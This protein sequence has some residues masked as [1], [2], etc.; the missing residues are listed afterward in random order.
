MSTP[1]ELQVIV[2]HQMWVLKSELGSPS[3][4]FLNPWAIFL[5]PKQWVFHCH[6]TPKWQH[7]DLM[8]DRKG[9]FGLCPGVFGD[10]PSSSITVNPQSSVLPPFQNELPSN[11]LRSCL[12]LWAQAVTCQSHALRLSP[13]PALSSL[14]LPVGDFPYMFWLFSST[15]A[16]WINTHH[17]QLMSSAEYFVLS[18]FYISCKNVF[19]YVNVPPFLHYINKWFYNE[20][21]EKCQGQ[22]YLS[23]LRC[24][25]F[26]QYLNLPAWQKGASTLKGR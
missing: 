26:L 17:L 14:N 15:R 5:A 12:F 11:Y 2:S 10:P 4:C 21:V 19:L 8:I 24:D 9:R 22:H 13:S 1:V 20:T 16:V 7:F 25:S 6:L 23:P 3:L 18:S